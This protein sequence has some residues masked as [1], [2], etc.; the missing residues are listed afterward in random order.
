MTKD[1]VQWLNRGWQPVFI[2]FCPSKK[3]WARAIAKM[4]IKNCP[5]YPKTNG[6]CTRFIDAEGKT[7]VLVTIRKD[8]DRDPVELMGLIVHEATHAWQFVREAIGET[9]PGHELEA[10]ALQNIT[11][12]LLSA[13]SE[14]RGVK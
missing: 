11:I 1:E 8:K 2:G 5:P 3:A 6:S 13:Y 10:Y 4:R 12:D 14:T 7:I 9:N